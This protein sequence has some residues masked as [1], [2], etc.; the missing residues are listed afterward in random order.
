MNFFVE[1]LGEW[2][3]IEKVLPNHSN[4]F[5][6]R[7]FDDNKNEECFDS[8]GGSGSTIPCKK[9]SVGLKVRTKASDSYF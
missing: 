8:E 6:K 3:Q 4:G 9:I 5:I 1:D 2:I 7:R